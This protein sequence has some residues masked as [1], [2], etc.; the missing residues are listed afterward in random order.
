MS[1][2]I[3]DMPRRTVQHAKVLSRHQH[4]CNIAV[5][6]DR[7]ANTA[8][9][10]IIALTDGE[11]GIGPLNIVVDTMFSVRSFGERDDI[12]RITDDHIQIGENDISLLD[13][14]VWDPR[15]DWQR[16]RAACELSA[17]RLDWMLD[18]GRRKAPP[19][20]LLDLQSSISLRPGPDSFAKDLF[21]VFSTIL[22]NME[23]EGPRSLQDGAASLTGLGNGLTPAGDDFLL[24][25]MLFTWLR[26]DS[27][28]TICQPLA[29]AAE[30]RTTRL[31]AC[32]LS[33]AAVGNCSTHWHSFFASIAANDAVVIEQ[34]IGTLLSYGHTS[35]ADALAGFIWAGCHEHIIV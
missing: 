1:K 16:L 23:T 4:V 15:P 28:T 33:Q 19:G 25:I 20:S 35:G 27:A 5:V 18:V 21:D 34:N 10:Q 17:Q 3:L 6:A 26:C 13:A 31:S 29:R 12:V 30:Q 32:L 24:G 8:P 9:A 22:R 11:I 7:H 14:V 2:A